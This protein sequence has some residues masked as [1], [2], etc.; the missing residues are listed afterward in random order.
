[1]KKYMYIL[2]AVLL[3]IIPVGC[4]NTK[5]NNNSNNTN[6]NINENTKV[7]T[8]AESYSKYLEL[9]SDS[10]D[11]MS[12]AIPEDDY[13]M[14]MSLVGFSLVDLTMIPITICGL[15]ETAAKYFYTLYTNL[16]YK[17]EKDKCTL[18]FKNDDTT[19]KYISTYDKNTDSV[20]TKYYEDDKLKLVAEYV[21][22]DKGYGTQ[23]YYADEDQHTS[24]RSIFS[25]DY[26]AIGT[27]N[28]VT[29]EP[30]SIYKN[31]NMPNKE[32]TQGGT[33][34]TEYS[35]GKIVTIPE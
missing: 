28:D 27:F 10:Y 29:I 5:D 34:W 23:Q 13:T 3:C 16:D 11:K 30:T 7:S 22:L 8:I 4:G 19:S 14:A 31:K 2:L 12:E 24:Y 1:M 25:E 20:Q 9:K 6:N 33:S 21:K 26:I 17:N 18:T 32:W 35:N 15:D